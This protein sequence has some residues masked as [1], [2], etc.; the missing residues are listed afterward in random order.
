MTAGSAALLLERL[1]MHPRFP[2]LLE[3]A[4]H[5]APVG[6]RDQA[7]A[8]ISDATDRLVRIAEIV[9]DEPTAIVSAGDIPGWLR[10]GVLDAFASFVSGNATTCCHDPHPQHPEPD[11]A[12]VWKPGLITCGHCV[13]LFGVGKASAADRT[14][15]SCGRV[16]EG[17]VNHDPI[18][19]GMVQISLVTVQYGT[20]GDCTPARAGRPLEIGRAHV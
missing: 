16:C 17:L 19:P 9:S 14:C 15:D 7:D 18:H 6:V 3:Q 1:M 20:C 12:A 11:Y 2:E 5:A 4:R 8:A 10:L 13:H